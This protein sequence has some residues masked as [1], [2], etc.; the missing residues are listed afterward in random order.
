ME[1]TIYCRVRYLFLNSSC[2][3]GVQAIHDK[4]HRFIVRFLLSF[5]CF[6]L[7]GAPLA[8]AKT[9]ESSQETRVSDAVAQW[10]QEEL[11]AT[12]DIAFSLR[13][14]HA[15][16]R[17]PV[18]EFSR[19]GRPVFLSVFPEA[20]APRRLIAHSPDAVERLVTNAV[21]TLWPVVAAGGDAGAVSEPRPTEEEECVGLEA[22]AKAAHRRLVFDLARD[23]AVILCGEGR[24]KA[25]KR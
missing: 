10:L 20:T 25:Q 15:P 5:Q 22:R 14:R 6:L 4:H 8:A 1:A 17:R 23:S 2:D 11:G 7:K 12:L 3:V 13:R 16:Q 24:R 18:A 9:S 21:A 19:E